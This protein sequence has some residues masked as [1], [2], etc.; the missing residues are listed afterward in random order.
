VSAGLTAPCAASSGYQKLPEAASLLAGAL[1]KI[2]TGSEVERAAAPAL[3][4]GLLADQAAADALQKSL[5]M[6]DTASQTQPHVRHKVLHKLLACAWLLPDP[7]C[8][9]AWARSLVWR[10]H[11]RSDLL[12]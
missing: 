2:A 7:S 11:K 4:N 3:L 6:E 9:C 10:H 8:C 5:A 1:Q 12:P